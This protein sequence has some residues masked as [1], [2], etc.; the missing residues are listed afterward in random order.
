[1][2]RYCLALDLKDNR[3]AIETYKE[4]HKNVWPEI[5]E[6]IKAAGVEKMEIYN[7]Y[8]RLFMII[9]CNDTFSFER[10]DKI[11]GAN[12]ISDKWEALMSNYQQQL[13]NTKPNEKWVLMDKIYEL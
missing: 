3:E 4:Y 12:P 8:N 10:W 11:N 2:K 7:V 13:P 6:S 9:E 1:M 5:E